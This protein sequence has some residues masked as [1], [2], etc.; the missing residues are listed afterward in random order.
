MEEAELF[1]RHGSSSNNC[2]FALPELTAYPAAGSVSGKYAPRD[3]LRLWLMHLR[4]R[5]NI[6]RLV[7]IGSGLLVMLIVV[8]CVFTLVTQEA[9]AAARRTNNN[10]GATARLKSADH[11]S[12]SDAP[13]SSSVMLSRLQSDREREPVS[14]S[15]VYISVKT[16]AK[17]GSP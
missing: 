17:E 9:Q 7:Q 4:T 13:P 5:Q 12:D 8:V 11:H 16:S 10:S 2:A 15:D 1:T 14:L 3:Q 6:Q